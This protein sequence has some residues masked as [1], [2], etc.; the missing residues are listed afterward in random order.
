MVA[1]SVPPFSASVRVVLTVGIGAD[2]LADAN[3]RGGT[4]T[5]ATRCHSHRQEG[6]VGDYVDAA[7]LSVGESGADSR[8][9]CQWSG[10]DNWTSDDRPLTAFV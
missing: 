6:E 7:T 3:N 5:I 4:I 9:W 8:G 10:H 2:G 1:M